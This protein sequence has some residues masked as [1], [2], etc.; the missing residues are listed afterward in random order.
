MVGGEL[1]RGLLWGGRRRWAGEGYGGAD[2]A[3]FDSSREGF[4]VQARGGS[5]GRAGVLGDGRGDGALAAGE[6][7]M[8]QLVR[9]EAE[10]LGRRTGLAGGE[11]NVVAGGEGVGTAGFRGTWWCLL[12]PHGSGI[13]ADERLQEAARGLGDFYD[14]A[15]GQE[16]RRRRLVWRLIGWRDELWL[17]GHGGEQ[18]GRHLT[19]GLGLEARVRFRWLGGLARG[20]R[21]FRGLNSG[22][23]SG[24]DRRCSARL[25]AD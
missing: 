9:E 5:I 21:G 10:G 23:R 25:R 14:C 18:A 12:D 22:G 3:R 8:G 7:D 19:S 20:Y 6:G 4:L 17:G 16:L 11:D 13:D 1:E 24:D 15:A 2:D